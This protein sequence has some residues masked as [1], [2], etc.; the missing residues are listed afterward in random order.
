MKSKCPMTNEEYARLVAEKM[1]WKLLPIPNGDGCHW[2]SEY[3]DANGRRTEYCQDSFDPAT[4]WE[5]A[6]VWIEWLIHGGYTI[7][8]DNYY[9]E[10][11]TTDRITRD[12]AS[13]AGDMTLEGSE[14]AGPK[15]QRETLVA[16]IRIDGGRKDFVGDGDTP[17]LALKAASE[18]YLAKEKT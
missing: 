5:S 7:L 15:I 6:G 16:T 4:D 14:I 2:W 1:G 11:E 17:L 9:W 10:E 18:A 8:L 3:E 12:M 13:D